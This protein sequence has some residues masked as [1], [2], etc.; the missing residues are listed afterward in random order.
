[1]RLRAAYLRVS[2][3]MPDGLQ[4][5]RIQGREVKLFR[6][7]LLEDMRFLQ[8]ASGDRWWLEFF[9]GTDY[10]QRFEV[11]FHSSG[12][13]QTIKPDP[14]EKY[15]NVLA[16][17]EL[18][19]SSSAK[20]VAWACER[21]S[22]LVRGSAAIKP[23]DLY[24]EATHYGHVSGRGLQYVAKFAGDAQF[25]RHVLLH[26][27]AYAYL[28]TMEK[29]GNALSHMLPSTEACEAPLRK[30]YM[31]VALFNAKSFFV[32]PVKLSN[33]HF[34]D[35]WMRIDDV[36]CMRLFNA[37]L[38]KQVQSAHHIYA[39]EEEKKSQARLEV[40]EAR[41]KRRSLGLAVCGLLLG[42]AGALSAIDVVR[43]WW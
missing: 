6:D 19:H 1:M 21:T 22:M 43:G 3:C 41:E 33:S 26:A 15:F 11:A 17:A 37:E 42:A 4:P 18:T 39:L 31:D 20:D 27:L 14:A 2:T 13:G 29:M 38:T 10:V 32:Q 5:L 25:E 35:A 9:R 40:Q 36:L 7:V 24:E 23:A 34:C 12:A 28:M 30:L 8:N 16:Y